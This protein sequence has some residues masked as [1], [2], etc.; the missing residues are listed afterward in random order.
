MLCIN[1]NSL[2]ASVVLDTEILTDMGDE[3]IHIA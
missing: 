1:Q 3:P 2:I